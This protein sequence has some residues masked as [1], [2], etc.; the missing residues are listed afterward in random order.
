M[1]IRPR[2]FTLI[3]MLAVLAVAALLAV[4]LA[5]LVL[6]AMEDSKGQQA[7]QHQQRI[8]AAAA[9]YLAANHATLASIATATAPARVTVA[10]L[11]AAGFLSSA[12]EAANPYGQT[13][14]MLVLQPTPGKLEALLVTE[15]AGAIP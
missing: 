6:S 1:N 2:G 4:G 3:E 5:Q 8:T 7:G 14:C 10:E 11:Q 9:R 12:I 13:P 15:G